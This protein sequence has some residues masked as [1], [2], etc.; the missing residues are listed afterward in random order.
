M[1]SNGYNPSLIPTNYCLL[2]GKGG[3]LVRHEVYHGSRRS[4]SK[5]YGCWVCLCPTCHAKVHAQPKINEGLEK[6]MQ[7]RAM[8]EHEWTEDDFRVVFGKSYI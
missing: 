8:E 3:D 6:L 2:C 5:M 4:K 1:D 7:N